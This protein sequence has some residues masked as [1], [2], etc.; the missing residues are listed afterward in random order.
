MSVVLRL[1][2]GRE[3]L[4]VGDAAYTRRTIDAGLRPWRV[5]DEHLYGRSLRELQIYV[6]QNPDALV[7]PGH[8]MA[9]WRKLAAVY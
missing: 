6:E 8:D 7:I 2:E 4:L 3:A 9:E 1:A 5:E